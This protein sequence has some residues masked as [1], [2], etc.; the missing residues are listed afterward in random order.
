[1]LKN[2]FSQKS[3]NTILYPKLPAISSYLSDYIIVDDGWSIPSTFLQQTMRQI[4]VTREVAL[5]EVFKVNN[6]LEGR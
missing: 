6:F 4:E 2:L 3:E 5:S 1:M